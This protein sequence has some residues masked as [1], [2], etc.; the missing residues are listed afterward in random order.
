MARLRLAKRSAILGAVLLLLV[1]VLFLGRVAGFPAAVVIVSGR[2]M[3]P[4]LHVGDIVVGVK[5][6][7]NVS[8]IVIW[9][10]GPTYCV[11]HRVVEIKDGV[12]VTKGDNNPSPDPPVPKSLVR[13]KVV[14]V[15]R[16]YV[17]LPAVLLALLAYAYVHRE[18]FLKRQVSPGDVASLMVVFF[19]VFNAAIAL[20]AP[21]YYSPRGGVMETP[22]VTLK[23]TSVTM[24]GNVLINLNVRNTR[25]LSVDSCEALVYGEKREYVCEAIV[26]SNSQI[27]V[28]GIPKSLLERMLEERVG[29][30]IIKV[31]A[32]IVFGV[33]NGIYYV[34]PTWRRPE[35]TITNGSVM[36]I[37]PNPASLRV[38]VTT[39]AANRPGPANVSF[40]SYVLE[41]GGSVR[42]DL[43]KYRYAY[44]RVEY[45]FQGKHVIIQKRVRP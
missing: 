15:I 24:N 36:I 30:L 18:Y 22:E 1:I 39:Y 10:A 27:L 16:W 25:L 40:K 13:Y 41:A 5:L 19:V 3:E 33:L 38:N 7:Y 23:G 31:K 2:S 11:V 6:P 8:D 26:V 4:T 44:I 20:L 29:P 14:G 42:I 43:S 35:V 9:C 45:L 32:K 28:K 21:T 12:I 17:W 37:N 34:Y